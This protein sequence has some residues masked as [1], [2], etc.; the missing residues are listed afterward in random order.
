MESVTGEVRTDTVENRVEEEYNPLPLYHEIEA[1]VKIL[2]NYEPS[3]EEAKFIVCASAFKLA[4]DYSW[5]GYMSEIPWSE[6]DQEAILKKH[7]EFPLNLERGDVTKKINEFNQKVIEEDFDKVWDEYYQEF[8]EPELNIGINCQ[9]MVDKLNKEDKKDLSLF[10]AKHINDL[11]TNSIESFGS[12]YIVTMLENVKTDDQ[13]NRVSQVGTYLDNYVYQKYTELGP[14]FWTDEVASLLLEEK[15]F[16]YS[17]GILLRGINDVDA[18][19]KDIVI[20]QILRTEGLAS[21]VNT[22]RWIYEAGPREEG[23]EI[24]KYLLGDLDTK[25]QLNDPNKKPVPAESIKRFYEAFSPDRYDEKASAHASLYSE[26]LK[27]YGKL[28]GNAKVLD[29]GSGNGW[30]TGELKHQGF[31]AQGL[32][33]VPENVKF[34]REMYGPFFSQGDWD[35]LVDYYKK[36]EL[37][38]VIIEGRGVRHFKNA[39]DARRS[40]AAIGSVIKEGGVF[41]FSASNPKTGERDRVKLENYRDFNER[42]GFSKNWLKDYYWTMVGAPPGQIGDVEQFV[43]S[44][45]PPEDWFI[46][47][48][49]SEGFGDIEI[50]REENYDEKGTENLIFFAKKL[51]GKKAEK[52]KKEAEKKLKELEQNQPTNPNGAKVKFKDPYYGWS[53]EGLF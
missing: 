17:T 5:G 10:M 39:L 49:Q 30:L 20:G 23:Q 40:I 38:A 26:K 12:T 51:S 33:L 45:V 34:A 25:A 9:L 11:A 50:V 43:E 1:R 32:E 35:N 53:S 29:L 36:G 16:Y 52:V 21:V 31:D 44:Y 19:K 15:H 18:E 42:F 14:N 28:K 2:P 4:D 3:L 24:L 46:L 6:I 41:A 37:D 47:F 7:Q 8:E 27:I 22:A 13:D 48:L